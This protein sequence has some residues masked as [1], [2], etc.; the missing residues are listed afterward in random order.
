[1]AD[2]EIRENNHFK[3]LR[4]KEA[5]YNF[6]KL[7]GRMY[8]W[9]RTLFEDA[10][11]FPAP[12]LLD[13]EVTT[14]CTGVNGKVCPFCY[15]ANT[16]NGKNMSFETFK[17][18]LDKFPKTLTQIA[19]GAD[20]TLESNPELWAMMK[21][22]KEKGVVPN[23]TCAQ[24]SDRIADKLARYCGAVA[25]S[26]YEDKDVCY[27]SVYKL[28]SRGMKQVNI[29]LMISE[30]TYNT[31]IETINDFLSDSRLKNLNAIVCLS[32][33][34]KGRGIGYTS[35]S[36]E[37]FKTLVDLAIRNKVGLGFDSCSSLKVFKSFE[38]YEHKEIIKHSII[39]CESTLESSYISVD[40]EFF[41]CSFMEGVEGWESGLDVINCRDFIEDIWDNPRT[42]EFRK[43]LLATEKTN[44][45]RTCPFY[46]V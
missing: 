6:D 34:R 35:L 42:E 9:G 3:N 45:C 36:Q 38:G 15:K 28:T 4:S 16:P 2:F 1:M 24:I 7:T 21:Y 26:R 46:E 8:T 39:P 37:K 5:N 41:P 10:G 29:H 11:K 13:I 30:E 44:F 12:T 23:I 27:N 31:A 32:L 17:T 43:S 14:R 25:V 40:G 20:A 19:F 33:K 22:A 18:I